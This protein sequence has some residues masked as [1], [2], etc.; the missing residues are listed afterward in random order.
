MNFTI[1]TTKE[2]ALKIEKQCAFDAKFDQRSYQFNGIEHYAKFSIVSIIAKDKTIS[3][4]DIFWL[5]YYTATV[6]VQ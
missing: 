5:G 6:S 2:T 1:T 4:D 3:P